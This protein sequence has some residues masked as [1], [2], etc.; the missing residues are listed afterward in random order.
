GGAAVIALSAWLTI[1]SVAHGEHW[2]YQFGAAIR[3]L[4]TRVSPGDAVM[5]YPAWIEAVPWYYGLRPTHRPPPWGGTSEL[6]HQPLDAIDPARPTWLT[7]AYHQE[8][9]ATD[10]APD[11]IAAVADLYGVTFDRAAAR[12]VLLRHPI[13]VVHIDGDGDRKSGG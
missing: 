12:A 11:M 9:G 4:R 10:A 5:Y 3:D 6:A 1:Q 13:V 7:I 8:T 2:R